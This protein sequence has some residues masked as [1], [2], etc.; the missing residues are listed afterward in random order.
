VRANI[1]GRGTAGPRRPNSACLVAAG[2]RC[3]AGLLG[4]VA[5]RRCQAGSVRHCPSKLRGDSSALVPRARGARTR[6]FGCGVAGC[7]RGHWVIPARGR[8]A[9][10]REVGAGTARDPHADQVW[11]PGASV[12]QATLSI[13][14]VAPS[15]RWVAPPPV[16]LA[17]FNGWAN[18]PSSTPASSCM[19]LLE[20]MHRPQGVWLWSKL[21]N[22]RS[23]VT[24]RS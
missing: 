15:V 24:A 8:L 23:L 20:A 19:L 6:P 12:G 18:T 7:S 17:S 3:W 13:R 9:C 21:H 16:G 2:R 1:V 22:R 11:R 10:G 14:H 5:A 4:R